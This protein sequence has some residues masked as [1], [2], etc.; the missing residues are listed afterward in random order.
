MS[1]LIPMDEAARILG[2]TVEQL[3]E[4]RSN[5]EIFGYKDGSNW[6][7]KMSELERVGSELNITLNTSEAAQVADDIS[8]SFGFDL[9]DSGEGLLDEDESE[10]VEDLDSA[11]YVEDSS[12]ELLNPVDSGLAVTSDKDKINIDGDQELQL[13]DS[14]ILE[15]GPSSTSNSLD[16]QAVTLESASDKSVLDDDDD[17]LSFGSSSL[18]LASESSKKLAEALDEEEQSGDTGKLLSA[19]GDDDFALPE[20]DFTFADD[21]GSFEDSA[22]LSSDFED[23]GALILD[24]SDSSTEITL[25]AN[26]S[27][28]NLSASASG[29]SLDDSAPLDL[30]MSD[31]DELEL[32]GDDDDMI[33]LDDAASPDAA[34]MMLQEDDFDLTPLE[35]SMDDDDSS[36]SQVIALEDSEIY[37]D[38]SAA[39]ILGESGDF[40]S[41]P[42]MLDDGL[43]AGAPGA[44]TPDNAYDALATGAQPYGQPGMVAPAAL[45]EAPYSF[46]Q[47]AALS[48]AALL[49][50]LGS[51]IA[52][53]LAQNLWMP[54]DYVLGSSIVDFFI[55]LANW[56]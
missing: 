12:V 53:N 52:Y 35:P 33:V 27:G 41:Q 24:D 13:A 39:T 32:P 38:D 43:A 49:M 11:E 44:Y 55:D 4:L 22:E 40:A 36:G 31:I 17:Q 28:I 29:I 6:K 42:Q 50:G 20:D 23:S 47:V 3:S 46:A 56:N 15:T 30:G 1:K 10:V 16:D 25:E 26:E 5:N 37:A 21:S 14:G 45:P 9:A 2:M 48:A 19:A 34:T 54:Q 51:M 8:E 7:F 18:S